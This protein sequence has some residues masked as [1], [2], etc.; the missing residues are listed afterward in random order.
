MC[1][2]KGKGHV[3]LPIHWLEPDTFTNTIA[4]ESEEDY[5]KVG[6]ICHGYRVSIIAT[7]SQV[8]DRG[9]NSAG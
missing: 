1:T 2:A 9:H 8:H 6:N 5:G 4:E 7:G 3:V